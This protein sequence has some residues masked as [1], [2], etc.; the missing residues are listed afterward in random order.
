MG[1]ARAQAEQSLVQMVAITKAFPGV[2]ALDRVN[3]DLR[4]GEVHALI[5]ENG[6]G[7]STLVKILTGVYAKDSGE[8]KLRGR[9]VD[10][11]TPL[12][13]QALGIRII[14]QE[15]NLVND[16][17]IQENMFLETLAE[18]PWGFVSYGELRKQSAKVLQTLGLDVSP[19]TLV[20]DLSVGEQQTVEIATALSKEADVIIMDEPTAALT[21]AEVERLFK[22]IDRLRSQGTAV[23]YISHKLDEVLAIA[24]RATV[25]RDGR[26][27]ATDDIANL[28]RD[29]IVRMMVGRPL[30][31]MYVRHRSPSREVVLEVENLN[32][33]GRVK[34]ASLVA[35]RGEVVGI[36]G[37]MGAGQYHLVRGIFGAAAGATGTIR[38]LGQEI[39]INSPWDAIRHGIGLLTENRKE[40]GLV[41][42]LNVMSNISLASL[43]RLNRFGFLDHQRERS[44]ALEYVKELHIR[45][46]SL[47]QE[48]EFLSGGN[49]QK[50]VLAKWLATEPEIIVMAEPTR[51]VDVGAKAE[52]YRLIDELASQGKVVLVVSSELPEVINLSDRIYVMHEG[53]IVVELDAT[54]TSQEEIGTYATGGTYNEGD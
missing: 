6:A 52:A 54:K 36:T 12:A 49:Q 20:R 53:R 14:H 43:Q 42:A 2:L 37:L 38:L 39:K 11:Q 17:S 4:E 8:I 3:F 32:I 13:A 51:G 9:P 31:N 5:G 30:Q 50:V 18:N 15:F 47:D 1:V 7:K 48:V 46:P 16:M 28:N 27:I 29:K 24:D 23:V 25:L 35:H 19:N 22:I 34:N 40:E 41:L 21:D 45:T 44:Q 26:L 10:I 33:P